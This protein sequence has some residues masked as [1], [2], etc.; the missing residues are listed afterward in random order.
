MNIYFKVCLTFW[1]Y[2][3]LYSSCHAQKQYREAETK[4][5]NSLLD[6]D[7]YDSRMRPAGANETDTENAPVIVTVN[8]HLR[9]I[10]ELDDIKRQFTCQ[11]TFRQQW[12]DDRLKFDDMN[13]QIKYINIREGLSKI[14]TP[15]TFFRN[16]KQSH[17][18]N[19]LNPNVL[20]RLHS[21]G[22]VFYSTRISATFSCPINL[23]NYPLDTQVCTIAVT[24]CK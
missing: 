14:W 8:M 23:K 6:A 7:R 11:L 3:F 17:F 5:L 16:E 10:D 2:H 12:K 22:S 21:D 15:D 9:S 24:S 19:M 1:N 18:H 4:I 13:G 20:I